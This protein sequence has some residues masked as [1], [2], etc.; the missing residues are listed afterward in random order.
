MTPGHPLRAGH[1][2]PRHVAFRVGTLGRGLLRVSWPRPQSAGPTPARLAPRFRT[3]SP[4]LPPRGPCGPAP[5]AP[6]GCGGRRGR[7]AVHT[8]DTQVRPERA[9]RWGTRAARGPTVSISRTEPRG[10]SGPGGCALARSSAGC[11]RPQHLRLA[12]EGA[13][14]AGTG[15]T[16]AGFGSEA[17]EGRNG[18]HGKGDGRGSPSR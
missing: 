6:R 4:R 11:R 1:H 18:R 8:R 2:T 10:R 16:G 5:L 3:C 9:S 15:W 13:D 7:D 14:R 12:Q 17:K